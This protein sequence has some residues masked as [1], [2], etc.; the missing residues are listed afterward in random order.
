L[1]NE[2]IRKEKKL[3]VFGENMKKDEPSMPGGMKTLKTH[4]LIDPGFD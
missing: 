4:A 1:D 2:F 3:D